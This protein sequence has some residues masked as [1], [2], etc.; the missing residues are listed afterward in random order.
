MDRSQRVSNLS[1]DVLGVF[2]ERS[3]LSDHASEVLLAQRL[4]MVRLYRVEKRHGAGVMGLH[5]SHSQ[6]HLQPCQ[7]SG[8]Y[9]CVDDNKVT[10]GL[11]RAQLHALYIVFAVTE[12]TPFIRRLGRV[13]LDSCYAA[14]VES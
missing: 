8:L 5:V 9:Y 4:Q 14:W 10:L 12:A 6:G 13:D 2:R 11:L 1:Q 7:W 3:Q